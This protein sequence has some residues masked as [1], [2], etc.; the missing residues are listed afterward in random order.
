MFDVGDLPVLA[1]W[2]SGLWNYMYVF[3]RFFTFFSKS[4]KT[5]LFTFFWVVAHVFPNSG[6]SIWRFCMR[7]RSP[8][9]R[10]FAILKNEHQKC[11]KFTVSLRGHSLHGWQM[12]SIRS[13]NAWWEISLRAIAENVK[14]SGGN[15]RMTLPSS[16]VWEYL[17]ETISWCLVMDQ[18]R[19][20]PCFD[21]N[22]RWRAGF[23]PIFV[24]IPCVGVWWRLGYRLISRTSKCGCSGP[25]WW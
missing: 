2:L 14:W 22:R 19:Y 10:S 8:V 24:L 7:H 15:D 17:W 18:P 12:S 1:E 4:K 25:D 16:Y 6:V 21:D 20:V 23:D 13:S 5:W 11:P 3:L 9:I